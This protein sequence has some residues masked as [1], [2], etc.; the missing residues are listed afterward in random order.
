MN[1]LSQGAY[2]SLGRCT[3]LLACEDAVLF[4]LRLFGD[5]N[6]P[7]RVEHPHQFERVQRVIGVR[8]FV[9]PH[10][11]PDERFCVP[12]TANVPSEGFES[13]WSSKACLPTHLAHRAVRNGY[14]QAPQSENP[15]QV[16]VHSTRKM[17]GSGGIGGRKVR[18]ELSCV[19]I[20]ARSTERFVEVEEKFPSW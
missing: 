6:P 11:C 12:I 13:G 1:G 8:P 7:D 5:P 14:K 3:V 9:K 17:G 18:D 4:V 10:G 16:V 2:R 15:R 20:G 19:E